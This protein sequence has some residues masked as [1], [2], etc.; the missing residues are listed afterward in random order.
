LFAAS[1]RVPLVLVLLAGLCVGLSI[2]AVLPAATL[3]AF[4][5]AA[6]P[7]PCRPWTGHP[8]PT[9]QPRVGPCTGNTA[10]CPPPRPS[11]TSGTSSAADNGLPGR[12]FTGGIPVQP[13]FGS[14]ADTGTARFQSPQP[15]ARSTPT[16][17]LPGTANGAASQVTRGTIL[18]SPAVSGPGSSP[19]TGLVPG[20]SSATAGT[21]P[22]VKPGVP[23]RAGWHGSWGFVWN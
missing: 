23:R 3:P 2:I 16:P 17:T 7:P 19:R 18:P 10:A 14:P 15:Q 11:A 22:G 13:L 21:P 12:E 5:Q 9:P 1:G 4:G 8:C 20:G 6:Y